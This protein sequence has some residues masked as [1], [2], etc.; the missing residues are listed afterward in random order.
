M[1][2]D[3]IKLCLEAALAERNYIV[4]DLHKFVITY[5]NTVTP[6]TDYNKGFLDALRVVDSK[7][8]EI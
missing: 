6:D 3:E 4:S 2:S 7:I 5:L 8:K 1:T